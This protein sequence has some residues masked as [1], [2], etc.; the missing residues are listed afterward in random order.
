LCFVFVDG[1]QDGSGI[2][3][4]QLPTTVDNSAQPAASNRNRL[5]G[6]IDSSAPRP[7]MGLRTLASL[8]V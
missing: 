4:L 6:L 7:N 1:E 2:K 3:G 5:I 8:I